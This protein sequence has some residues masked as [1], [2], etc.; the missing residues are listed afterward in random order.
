MKVSFLQAADFST[1]KQ[2]SINLEGIF[3]GL[4]GSAVF[5]D[6]NKN[7]IEIYNEKQ[8]VIKDAPQSTF[9]IMATLMGLENGVIKNQNSQMHYNGSKYWLD[10][11]NKN[12]TLAEA[13]QFS[14]VWY[15]HQV[16][17]AIPQEKVT[18]F[19]KK[20]AYG[21][22]DLSQWQGNGSNAK[23][24]LNG[25]WLSSSLKIS[26]LEQVRVISDIFEN[27]TKI[28]KKHMAIL[29]D[30][31]RQERNFEKQS[32]ALAAQKTNMYAKTGSNMRGK[33]WFVGFTEKDNT[34]KYFAFYVND[35]QGGVSSA[36]EIALKYFSKI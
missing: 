6:P 26:P 28:D 9:K 29:K 2:K 10:A 34:R 23:K 27:K 36:K 1:I 3:Q 8:S 13:F 15:F 14:C 17:Y 24:E 18:Q 12:V 30:I 21:N 19:L 16:V 5:Y 20:I 7:I 22:E 32:S 11:W 33:S 25:F 4:N 31:M 35:A